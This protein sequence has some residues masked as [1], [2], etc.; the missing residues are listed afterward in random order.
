MQYNPYSWSSF[1]FEFSLFSFNKC[2]SVQLPILLLSLFLVPC[3]CSFKSCF[4]I[5]WFSFRF[6]EACL[7][8]VVP[9]T[10][11]S[12]SPSMSRSGT[13][14]LEEPSPFILLAPSSRVIFKFIIIKNEA[15]GCILGVERMERT[16]RWFSP[17]SIH[18][19]EGRNGFSFSASNFLSAFT[20]CVHHIVFILFTS[21][22]PAIG[23]WKL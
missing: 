17:V 13:F 6:H 10:S 20:A 3:W 15:R 2:I 16:G 23:L 19:P 21:S 9:G 22:L 4:R 11:C 18:V 14:S 12:S 1:L 8:L 7:L 5:L